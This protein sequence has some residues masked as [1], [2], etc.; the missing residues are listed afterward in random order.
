M[1]KNSAAKTVQNSVPIGF[2][3]QVEF[4]TKSQNVDFGADKTGFKFFCFY[5]QKQK[6]YLCSLRWFLIISNTT[7][8]CLKTIGNQRFIEKIYYRMEQSVVL[9]II[10]ENNWRILC[11]KKWLSCRHIAVV[12]KLEFG[13]GKFASEIK[14]DFKTRITSLIKF[15]SQLHWRRT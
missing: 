7:K 8:S 4:S 14:I 2:N 6:R 13:I 3:S 9:F 5:G 11:F 1:F 15:S 10:Y 12:E